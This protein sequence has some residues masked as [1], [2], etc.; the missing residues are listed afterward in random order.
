MRTLLIDDIRNLKADKIARTFEEGI[1]ALL[2]E[3]HW[4]L[5][6]LDHDLGQKDGLDGTGIMNWIEQN[7]EYK[8]SKIQ[9]VTSNPVGRQRMQVIIDRI[10]GT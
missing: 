1:N 8:P 2:Y 6:L 5:L 4:D 9:L 3:G 10:Y 7:L